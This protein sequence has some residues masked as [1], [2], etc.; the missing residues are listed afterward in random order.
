MHSSKYSAVS[1]ASSPV[2]VSCEQSQLASSPQALP[3]SHQAPASKEIVIAWLE[4]FS[5]ANFNPDTAVF[6]ENTDGVYTDLA[7][8]EYR[9]RVFAMVHLTPEFSGLFLLLGSVNGSYL[10]MGS[11]LIVKE[12]NLLLSEQEL[13]W[14]EHS[15]Y[16]HT[17][18]FGSWQEKFTIEIVLPNARP[19]V[20]APLM[21]KQGDRT[22]QEPPLMLSPYR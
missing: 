9:L 3:L 2:N 21:L 20:L 19:K 13:H 1:L 10:P 11:R 8:A 15:A 4:Q 16:V 18:V 14:T 22:Q 5:A 6:A 7:I 12:N 17:Q